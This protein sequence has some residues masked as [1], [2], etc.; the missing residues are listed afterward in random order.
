MTS[1]LSN[2]LDKE[3]TNRLTLKIRAGLIERCMDMP[4]ADRPFNPFS[5][6]NDPKFHSMVAHLVE[7]TFDSIAELVDESLICLLYTSDAADEP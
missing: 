5:P 6:G 3:L 4:P 1:T 7:R 2:Q